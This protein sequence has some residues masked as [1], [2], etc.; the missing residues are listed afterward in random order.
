MH[1][2]SPNFENDIESQ[3]NTYRMN[4]EF[5]MPNEINNQNEK[6]ENKLDNQVENLAVS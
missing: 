3:D 5:E 2:D 1:E 4:G 6:D